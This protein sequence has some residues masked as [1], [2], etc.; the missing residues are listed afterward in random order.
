M[1]DGLSRN[2]KRDNLAKMPRGLPVL[3]IAGD[4]DPVGAN[5]KGVK[6]CFEEFK[7]VGIRD[8]EIRLYPGARHETLN[9]SCRMQVYGDVLAWLDA[10]I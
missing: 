7:R 9:E 4:R 1:M 3:F 2:Q 8:A 6:R 5:G 10:H